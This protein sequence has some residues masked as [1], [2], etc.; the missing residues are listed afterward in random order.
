MV[1]KQSVH[2][3]MRMAAGGEPVRESQRPVERV[4]YYFYEARPQNSIQFRRLREILESNSPEKQATIEKLKGGYTGKYH[5][6]YFIWKKLVMATNEYSAD[7]SDYVV[8]EVDLT[9]VGARNPGSEKLYPSDAGA[10]VEQINKTVFTSK[11]GNAEVIILDS[12]DESYFIDQEFREDFIKQIQARH[13]PGVRMFRHD[14]FI[15]IYDEYRVWDKNQLL[16]PDLST[17]ENDDL[18]GGGKHYFGGEMAYRKYVAPYENKNNNSQQE[19]PGKSLGDM[20]QEKGE[21]PEQSIYEPVQDKQAPTKGDYVDDPR[22]R[23]MARNV[24][25]RYAGIETSAS[26]TR[27]NASPV[28][29]QTG[30]GSSGS[31]GNSP[32]G[33]SQDPEDYKRKA[34]ELE[35]LSKAHKDM[36]RKME[37]IGKKSSANNS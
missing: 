35:E 37:Q 5:A 29:G 28:P 3:V 4:K 22:M 24:V 13:R 8:Y 20:E 18:P 16:L 15:K 9:P 14:E 7:G 33:S 10:T 12:S 32:G 17:P 34:K 2:R 30:T 25:S 27:N 19:Q 21:S 31:S 23:K 6:D 11:A 26:I 1:N 36:A